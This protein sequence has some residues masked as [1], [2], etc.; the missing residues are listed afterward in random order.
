MRWYLPKKVKTMNRKYVFIGNLETYVESLGERKAQYNRLLT[1]CDTYFSESLPQVHPQ[2]STTYMGIAMV[3]LALA[4]LLGNDERYL[5]ECRRWMHTV[6]GYEKWG[7]AHLVNVDLSASWILFG[8]SLS[9]DWLKDFL[10]EDERKLVADKIYHHAVILSDYKKATEGHGWATN[11]WQNHNWINLTGLSAAGYAL[12]GDYERAPQFIEE[13]KENFKTVF[14]LLADD[15]SNYEGVSYWR[16]GGMWLF[17]YASMLKTQEGIDYFSKCEYLKNTFYYRLYQSAPDMARQLNFGD[18][19]DR[20]SGHPACVYYLVAHEYNN[21]HAQNLGNLVIRDFLREEATQSGVKPGILPEA[22]FEFLWYD[23]LVSE[24]AFETLPLVKKF[25][26]LGLVSIR[27][28]WKAESKAFS[29]KCGCPGGTKQWHE[30]W[31]L[32]R[33]KNWK[34]LSLSHHHPDNLSYILV[35]G[36]DYITCEDGYNRNILAV[37]HNLLLVDGSFTDSENCNDVYMDS[38][39]KRL[40]QNPSFD[41]VSGYFGTLD[42]FFTDQNITLFRAETASMYRQEQKMESVCRF[43]FTDKLDF[44]L[45]ID[46]FVSDCPHIYSIVSNTDEKAH[47]QKEGRYSYPNGKSTYTV[48]SDKAIEPTWQENKIVSVMTTQE[49]DKVCTVLQQCLIHS[50]VEKQKKQTFVECLSLQKGY[51][52]ITFFDDVLVVK[53]TQRVYE[54]VFPS[55]FFDYKITGK[56]NLVCFVDDGT[57]KKIYEWK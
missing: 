31:R 53:T 56:A 34:T 14:S 35:D 40:A 55:R 45:M 51:P 23:P 29:F 7:N 9:Y 27:S 38:I 42:S 47:C 13:A 5:N 24:E 50:S 15:G 21:G 4:Y 52:K 39:E 37:N 6:L 57:A 11:F 20:H 16:Y 12:K 54:F 22:C 8:L 3:N 33:E 28:G 30:G 2:K 1:Q 36:K 25:D 26:D 32:A 41:P 10:P 18:C 48:L 49:P 46:R 19:H 43:V 17:V 44:V